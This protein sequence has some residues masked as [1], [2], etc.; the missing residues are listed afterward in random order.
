[1]N[2]AENEKEKTVQ[3]G[4]DDF[5]LAKNLKHKALEIFIKKD[6]SGE[7]DV[8]IVVNH[9]KGSFFR[10]PLTE[11]A[12]MAAYLSLIL[13]KQKLE[14][15]DDVLHYV[16]NGTRRNSFELLKISNSILLR[17]KD[18]KLLMKHQDDAD[19]NNDS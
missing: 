16:C 3:I 10:T 4:L 11:T 7:L 8:N 15:I 9:G 17:K 1:V 6:N 19:N 2:N 18:L 13:K 12:K 14:Y 5:G